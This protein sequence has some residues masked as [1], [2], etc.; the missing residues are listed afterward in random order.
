MIWI[1]LVLA[2]AF[3]AGVALL[4]YWGYRFLVGRA[5]HP[6]PVLAAAPQRPTPTPT[7]TATAI[8]TVVPAPTET[9]VPTIVHL[10]GSPT[11]TR[12]LMGTDAASPATNQAVGVA[13]G[14][15]VGNSPVI[16]GNPEG[17]ATMEA[18][19]GAADG[20]SS[21]ISAVNSG[22]GA[23]AGAGVSAAQAAKSGSTGGQKLPQTGVGLAWP[24]VSLLCAGLAAGA[25]WLRGRR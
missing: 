12:P 25:H 10:E 9:R 16:G 23:S 4:G 22:P 13:E 15:G 20:A 24:L 6:S 14:Q 2:F 7:C 8:P 1:V 19:G 21:G 11:P 18:G 5:M 17:G 3:L